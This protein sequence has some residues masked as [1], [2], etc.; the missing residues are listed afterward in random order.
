MLEYAWTD[1]S[2]SLN[3]IPQ[4][5]E[6][7]ENSQERFRS[8]YTL[9]TQ[10]FPGAIPAQFNPRNYA[11]RSGAALW[12]SAPWHEVADNLQTLRISFR[13]RLQTK[14]G[15]ADNPR[16]R[17]WMTW[18]YGLTFFPQADRDNFGEDF[19]LF[20]N[21]YRWNF[22]DRTSLLTDSSFDL[23]DNAGRTW[24]IGVLTQRQSPRQPLCRLPRS[25]RR[26]I[27]Q[28]PNA[29]RQLQLPDEP[30]MDLHC[31]SRL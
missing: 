27:P 20:Y 23:F 31:L 16:I 3:D 10:I 8:R 6:I 30:Q 28:K 1:A 14:A 19:G 21:H 26:P 25:Q 4:Y 17:D 12:T 11:L 24:S 2:R 29:R 5:N 22:S 7:D 9:P 18:D 13:D 15:P